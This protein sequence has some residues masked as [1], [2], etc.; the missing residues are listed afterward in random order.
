MA[1]AA[2]VPQVIGHSLMNWA[3][4]YWP[5]V[6]ISLAVRAEP[7]LA[8]VVAIP[9]LGEIPAWTVIPGG[10][11]LLA[12]VYL[13]IHSEARQRPRISEPGEER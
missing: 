8:A 7:V 3:L 9:V 6:N 10:A 11:L 5:A 13:A 1:V 2:V 4:G 12:G